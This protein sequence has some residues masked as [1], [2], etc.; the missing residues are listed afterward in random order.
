MLFLHSCIAEELLAA[1][2][3]CGQDATLLQVG[4]EICLPGADA[5]GCAFVQS[6][7]NNDNCKV[8]VVQQGDTISSVASSLNVFSDDLQKLNNDATSSGVLKPNAQLRLPPWASNCGNPNDS[9]QKCRVYVVQAG[10]F[11][12]G[13]ASAYRVDAAALL[14]ANPGLTADTPLQNAQQIKIPPFDTSCGAGVISKPPTDTVL[15]C[16]GYRVQQGDDISSIAK[17][18]KTTVSEI[19]SVNAGLGSVVQPGAVVNLPPYDS[20]CDKPILVASNVP[21]QPPAPPLGPSV[22][23]VPPVAIAPIA[24]VAPRP[25]SPPPAVIPKPVP[26]PAPVVASPPS[27]VPLPPVPAPAVPSSA[28]GA[29]KV[30]AAVIVAAFAFAF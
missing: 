24:P 10:D 7:N 12:S 9:A 22:I 30:A 6:F 15:K 17:A 23:A 8:Y 4:Q 21:P 18:F 28:I 13:I 19:Q 14:A 29:G 11:I 1:I 5:A 20:T 27:P 2:A 26:A 3:A 25:S 16:R